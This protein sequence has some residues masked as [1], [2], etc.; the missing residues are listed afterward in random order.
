VAQAEDPEFKPQ[1]LKKKKKRKRK[2][3]HKLGVVAVGSCL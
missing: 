3:P 2:M 1:H